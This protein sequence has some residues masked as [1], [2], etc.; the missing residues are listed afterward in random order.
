MEKIQPKVIVIASV[1]PGGLTQARYM[2]E[3]LHERLPNARIIVAFFLLC[4]GW[5]LWTMVRK[6]RWRKSLFYL[7]QRNAAGFLTVLFLFA[8]VNWTVVITRFNLAFHAPGHIDYKYLIEGLPD[9]NLFLLEKQTLPDRE[10]EL[11]QTKS[12]DFQQRYAG[13]DWREW[14]WPDYRNATIKR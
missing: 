7:I 2:C 9:D 13:L 3:R 8:A 10:A 4:V 6:V 1:P 14:N 5:G 12:N 11:L